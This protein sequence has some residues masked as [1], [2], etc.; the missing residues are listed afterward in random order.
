MKRKRV[1]ICN[2]VCHDAKGSKCRCWCG[3]KFHG[4][5][6]AAAREEF[7]KEFK[8]LARTFEDFKEITR[9]PNLFDEPSTA[10][11]RAAFD[12]GRNENSEVLP[13]RESSS[14]TDGRGGVDRA[15]HAIG[16]TADD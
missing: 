3:G 2:R 5:G 9:Q 12:E 14:G 8:T 1:R 7:K 10:A 4:T 11:T 15:E 13:K 16:G 6:G